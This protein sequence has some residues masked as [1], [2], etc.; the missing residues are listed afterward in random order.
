MLKA[1]A[2]CDS[3]AEMIKAMRTLETSFLRRFGRSPVELER[4]LERESDG[5]TLTRGRM[6]DLVDLLDALHRERFGAPLITQGAVRGEEI[7]GLLESFSSNDEMFQLL[8]RALIDYRTDR[9]AL[10]RRLE[11]LTAGV[12][13]AKLRE[14][15]SEG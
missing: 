1:L 9:E 4:L 14:N 5:G 10:K 7:A 13:L 8:S 2:N 3:E 15:D 11:E 6:Q 12:S